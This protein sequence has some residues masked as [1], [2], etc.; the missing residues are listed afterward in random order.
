[1]PSTNPSHNDPRKQHQTNP[2]K[3]LNEL[4]TQQK[5]LEEEVEKLR[6]LKTMSGAMRKKKIDIERELE[7][8]HAKMAELQGQPK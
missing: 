8:I 7:S 6:D 1:M 4:V 5:V 2:D 3:Q